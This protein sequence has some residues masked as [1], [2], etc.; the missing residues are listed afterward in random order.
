MCGYEATLI[1]N[2]FLVLQRHGGYEVDDKTSSL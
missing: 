2:T 1:N